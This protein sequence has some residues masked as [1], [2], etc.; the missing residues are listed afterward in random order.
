EL[1]GLITTGTALYLGGVNGVNRSLVLAASRFMPTAPLIPTL[2]LEGLTR[3]Q[4]VQERYRDDPL[5]YFKALRVGMLA[6]LIR[7]GRQA[8]AL[9]PDLHLPYLALHGE[10]DPIALPA[11]AET[12][13]ERCG[14][15]DLT[16]Q[17]YADMRHEL[18]NEIDHDGVLRDVVTWIE[19]HLDRSAPEPLEPS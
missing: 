8:A 5:V 17:I 9:L 16:V 7:A 11:A 19:A 1:A 18:H 10:A 3:D 12:I 4:A 6:E 13:R 15:T 14:A 2:G